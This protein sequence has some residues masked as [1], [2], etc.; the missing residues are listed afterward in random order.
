[1]VGRVGAIHLKLDVGGIL[2][3][4]W[5][6]REEGTG[7]HYIPNSDY[8]PMP[9]ME[10]A[11]ALYRQAIV[12]AGWRINVVKGGVWKQMSYSEKRLIRL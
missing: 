3:L 4:T 2:F 9:D 5:G 1:M 6:L 8:I 7:F 11:E 10:P 12:L